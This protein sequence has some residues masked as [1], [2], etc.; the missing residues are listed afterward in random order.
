MLTVLPV[1]LPRD[2]AEV[3]N[4]KLP[5]SL[6]EQVGPKGFL[7]PLAARAWRALVAEAKSK[8][9]HLTYTYG[10]CYRDYASQRSLFV[11]R[12]QMEPIAGRPWKVWEGV[13]WYQKPATAMAA[14]PGTSNHGLGLAID[15]ALDNDLADGVGPDDAQSIMPAFP[16]F[17]DAALKYGFSF[18]AQ[19]EPWHVRYVAGDRIPDA[20]LAYEDSLKPPPPP[21]P[22]PTPS[23]VDRMFIIVGNADDRSDP[24]RWVWDGAVSMRRLTSEQEYT[25]LVNRQAVGLVKL[26]PA[27]SALGSPFWMSTAERSLYV[28]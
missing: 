7:H 8:G 11:S 27:F 21:V 1:T 5:P 16:W 26:H 6:L 2:L 10:G 25:D 19:S 18:E 12:Y 28:S 13:R 9:F 15:A 14:V 4:G 24:T 20:V 23:E 22:S 17:H 3:Q